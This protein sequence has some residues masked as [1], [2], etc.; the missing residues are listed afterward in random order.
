[1]PDMKIYFTLMA[2]KMSMTKSTTREQWSC[3]CTLGNVSENLFLVYIQTL[4]GNMGR[5]KG[6]SRWDIALAWIGCT[7]SYIQI[8][9]TRG[10]CEKG[11]QR[12]TLTAFRFLDLVTLAATCSMTQP[13][14]V[15][16]MKLPQPEYNKQT[17]IFIITISQSSF[18]TITTQIHSMKIGVLRS[19]L[20]ISVAPW[21]DPKSELPPGL[22]QHNCLDV[23]RNCCYVTVCV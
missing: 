20:K 8:I 1:M 5:W 12:H 14:L 6:T 22:S 19:T 21:Y 18:V 15:K 17:I 7:S 10:S 23:W 4:W 9:N 16:P 2:K 13:H 11:L 3:I